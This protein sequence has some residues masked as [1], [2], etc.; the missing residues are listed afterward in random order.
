MDR[1]I[2]D[3]SVNTT[4]VYIESLI[5]V[6]EETNLTEIFRSVGIWTQDYTIFSYL[7]GRGRKGGGVGGDGG[8]SGDIKY[9]QLND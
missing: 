4:S 9:E 5:I 8:M 7:Q 3:T 6:W 2:L 1:S